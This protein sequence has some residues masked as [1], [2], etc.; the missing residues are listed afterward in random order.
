MKLPSGRLA[1]KTK[2][3]ISKLLPVVKGWF[4][5]ICVRGVRACALRR[6]VC[7]S[8]AAR[9][10][11]SGN[12]PSGSA[13]RPKLAALPPQRGRGGLRLTRRGRRARFRARAKFKTEILVK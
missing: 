9:Q 2:V 13:E 3:I 6:W 1:I 8:E 11:G 12:P 4:T 10:T 7:V 5:G